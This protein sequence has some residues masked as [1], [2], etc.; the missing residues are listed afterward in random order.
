[1]TRSRKRAPVICD[2]H[3]KMKRWARRQFRARERQALATGRYEDAPLRK[4][5]ASQVW[6]HRDWVRHRWETRLTGDEWRWWYGK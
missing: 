4:Q 2:A 5:E 1:M 6:E 3:P